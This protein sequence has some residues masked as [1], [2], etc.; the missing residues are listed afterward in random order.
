[1]ESLDTYWQPW[2][3]QQGKYPGLL[4]CGVNRPDGQFRIASH[5]P[6][7][8]PARAAGICPRMA[9]AIQRISVDHFPGFQFSWSF[10]QMQIVCRQRPD[11]LVLVLFL[12]RDITAQELAAIGQISQDFQQRG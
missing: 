5:S 10:E 6:Q 11:R 9:A 2:L 3:E 12:R 1:M 8:T 4:A 7:V